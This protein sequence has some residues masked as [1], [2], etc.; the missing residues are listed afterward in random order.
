[1]QWGSLLRCA[2]QRWKRELPG[3]RPGPAPQGA[4]RRGP[5]PEPD[6]GLKP[7][8]KTRTL[9]QF[10]R[11][12]GAETGGKATLPTRS[13]ATYRYR[14]HCSLSSQSLLPCLPVSPVGASLL[15]SCWPWERA[16]R[17]R[18]TSRSRARRRW[19]RR[20]PR[21]HRWRARRRRRPTGSSRRP[22]RPTRLTP[23]AGGPS[24]TC[25]NR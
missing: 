25:S 10:P 22:P 2:V 18:V 7:L 3:R 16:R 11:A 13:L 17:S 12:D 4:C 8:L 24:A 5:E 15:S 23:A 21:R 9:L 20:T 19:W 1:V 14:P 6:G